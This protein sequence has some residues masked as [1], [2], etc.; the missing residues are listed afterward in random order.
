MNI[1]LQCRC[2]QAMV[3]ILV[4]LLRGTLAVETVPVV[5]FF[6]ITNVYKRQRKVWTAGR[7]VC[8][9]HRLAE[10]Q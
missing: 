5:G 7:P 10:N 3:K 1:Q 2:F 6:Y 9:C 4:E 8:H